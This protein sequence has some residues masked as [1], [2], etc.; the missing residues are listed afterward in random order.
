MACNACRKK[1]SR[2]DAPKH[3]LGPWVSVHSM[4]ALDVALELARGVRQRELLL[5]WESYSG[6]TA[7]ERGIGSTFRGLYRK[8]ANHLLQR[9]TEA[10]VEWSL[11]DAGT[12]TIVRTPFQE[13]ILRIEGLRCMRHADCLALTPEFKTIHPAL[14]RACAACGFRRPSPKKRTSKSRYR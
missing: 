9:M 5:G 10:G 6:S 7:K 12:R 3:N 11:E 8:G 13:K 2:R 14:A 4:P 1:R